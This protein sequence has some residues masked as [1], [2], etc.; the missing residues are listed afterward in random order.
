MRTPGVDEAFYTG[1]FRSLSSDWKWH[2]V[3]GAVI[4]IRRMMIFAD[5]EAIV[6]T[7]Y[8]GLRPGRKA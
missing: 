8:L 1:S 3:R 5:R 7:S 4:F 6:E 2:E